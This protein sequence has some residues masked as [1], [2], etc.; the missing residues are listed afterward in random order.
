MSTVRTSG[1]R[2]GKKRED[3]SARFFLTGGT[4]FLGSHIAVGLLRRGYRVTLLVRPSGARRAEDRMLELVDWFGMSE[5]D[6][7]GLRVVE[8]DI[9]L[10][11]LG[12][13]PEVYR[14]LLLETDEIIHCASSTAFSERKRAEVEAV[15]SG[16]LT[17]VLDFARG[18]GAYFFHHVSTAFVAGMTAGACPEGLVTPGGFWNAYEETKCK[19]EHAAAAACGEAGLGLTIYRPSI[20]YGDSRT[21]RSLLFNAVYYPVRT[22]LFIRDIYEKDIREGGGRKAAEMGVRI[23]AGGSIHLPLRIEVASEGG[24]DLVPIDYF[25]EAFLALM[26][27]TPGGGVFHIVNGRPKRIEDIIDYSCRLFRMTGIRA[28]GPEEFREKPRNPLEA[29]YERYVEAYG[30]Y[31]RDDRVF[32]TAR[33]QAILGPRGIVCPEFDY[34][35]FARCMNYAIEA[36]WGS[37]LF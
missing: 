13:E 4:G 32:E 10:P 16:G 23:E 29:L 19:G 36:G 18:S 11:G 30:P 33:S 14:R 12:I 7:R 37:R 31:M 6:R 24:I 27:G 9:T 20:V 17:N 8:G 28:C 25:T 5:G 35:I 2:I 15:N 34:G 1:K 3:R 26:E 22:A 21:G